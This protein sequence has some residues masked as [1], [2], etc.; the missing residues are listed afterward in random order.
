MVGVFFLIRRIDSLPVGGRGRTALFSWSWVIFWSFG[1]IC[2][3]LFWESWWDSQFGSS[4][5]FAEDVVD[6]T[7]LELAFGTESG[8]FRKLDNVPCAQPSILL[9]GLNGKGAANSVGTFVWK[10]KTLLCG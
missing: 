2:V 10:Q 6:L 5:C 3:V 9:Q 1:S 8:L 7:I 4:H